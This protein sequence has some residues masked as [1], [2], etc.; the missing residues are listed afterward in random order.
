MR[1]R[2]IGSMLALATLL[3]GVMAGTL[4][5]TAQD[6]ATPATA[7]SVAHPAHIHV[8]T[9]EELG[10]VVHPLED[11]TGAHLEGTPGATPEAADEG[12][13]GDVIAHSRTT[14]EA[15][16]D[17]LLAEEHAVNVHESAENID[18]YIACANIEG[19]AEEGELYL[20]LQ[21]L[22][23]SG[24]TGQVI[25]SQAD[26]NSIEVTITLTDAAAEGAATTA[27]ATPAS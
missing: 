24:V 15:N 1:K 12:L 22:N 16:L 3:V 5:A 10:D 9:C 17:D 6:A 13:P 7:D 11:V 2:L 23:D 27:E 8:G 25:L 19:E 4:A 21:E 18:V 26:D 14:I 20:E